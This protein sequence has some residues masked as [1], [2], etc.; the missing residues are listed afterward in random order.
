MRQSSAAAEDTETAPE[1]MEVSVRTRFPAVMAACGEQ[2]GASAAAWAAPHVCM[3]SRTQHAIDPVVRSDPHLEEPIQM[4]SK[5]RGGLPGEVHSL[6]LRVDVTVAQGTVA[7]A[8]S[9]TGP[10][11]T[12]YPHRVQARAAPVR[13]KNARPQRISRI[14]QLEAPVQAVPSGALACARI[15]PSPMTSESR[16]AD[17]RRRWFAASRS[18]R[19]KRYF[20]SSSSGT[21]DTCSGER[22]QEAAGLAP[23]LPLKGTC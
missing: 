1:E 6:H 17:T 11:P 8:R 15:W 7:W 13:P 10:L 5:P 20:W 3:G 12:T 18:R 23:A 19:R 16:P 9:P 14:A 22:S 4:T 21:P 2:G